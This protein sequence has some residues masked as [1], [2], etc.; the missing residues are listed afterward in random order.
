MKDRERIALALSNYEVGEELGRG[1]WGVVVNA[2]H[3]QLDRAVAVK[4]LSAALADLPQV[5]ERFVAEARLLAELEHPHIVPIYDFVE[6]EG[7]CLL[8]M[9]L[10]PGG[11]L[12]ARHREA[13]L[14]PQQACAAIV[15]VCAALDHAHRNGVLHRDVKPDNVMFSRQGRLKVTDFGIAKVIAGGANRMTQTGMVLGTPAYMAPE[16]AEGKELTPAT[17]VYGAGSVLYELLSGRLPFPDDGEALALLFKRVH[18][19]PQPL[20]GARPDLPPEL[21]EVVDRSIAR[22]PG[23]RYPT[24][25]AFAVDLCEAACRAWGDGWLTDS[26]INVEPSGMLVPYESTTPSA[27]AFAGHASAPGEV[28]D[29][30]ARRRS[31]RVRGFVVAGVLLTLV[32]AGALLS[33]GGERPEVGEPAANDG[34]PTS[35][36]PAVRLLRADRGALPTGTFI[37]GKLDPRVRFT[38]SDG[39]EKLHE[40][41][42]VLS[43]VEASGP[44]RLLQMMWLERVV[45]PDDAAFAPEE[46]VALDAPRDLIAWIRAHPRLQVH[47]PL[48]GQQATAGG[49]TVEFTVR[50]GYRSALCPRECVL[51]F[52][53][54]EDSYATVAHE[55][56]RMRVY[57]VPTEGEPLIAAVS[58]PEA[59]FPAFAARADDV[60]ESVALQGS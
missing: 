54:L 21:S 9:E 2:H 8:V 46:R 4:Q 22:G 17:D 57:V 60:V 33:R 19:D 24:A 29:A 27:R 32:L 30:D 11:T 26:G 25:E 43:V 37:T 14:G 12:A 15:A 35:A 39:W 45:R 49:A 23:D 52:L 34:P 6:H 48:P 5:R 44:S 55:G 31:R 28:V 7:L 56:E 18:E 3:R 36:R 42:R 53:S 47:A 13:G 59:E 10:L 20:R 51:L 50:N 41:S 1:S 38:V 16:Q 58:A 40:S